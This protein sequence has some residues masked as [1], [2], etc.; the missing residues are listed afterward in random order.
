MKIKNSNLPLKNLYPPTVFFK[1]VPPPLPNIALV[2]HTR[3]K[4]YYLSFWYLWLFL[5]GIY[6]ILVQKNSKVLMKMSSLTRILTTIMYDQKILEILK[7]SNKSGLSIR[8]LLLHFY[9]FFR[10]YSGS[11]DFERVTWMSVW[12]KSSFNNLLEAGNF[13]RFKLFGTLK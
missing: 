12:I 11:F 1:T 7:I 9:R 10:N 3:N 6:L 2:K 5:H 4:I 8:R 13:Q